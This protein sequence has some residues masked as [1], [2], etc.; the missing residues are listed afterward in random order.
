MRAN[1]WLKI[2]EMWI[3]SSK[4]LFKFSIWRKDWR[5]VMYTYTMLIKKTHQCIVISRF[6]NIQ[7]KRSLDVENTAINDIDKNSQIH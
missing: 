2:N 7:L 1:C 4:S 3:A 5:S 6:M